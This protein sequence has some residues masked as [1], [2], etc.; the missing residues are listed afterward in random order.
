MS[1]NVQQHGCGRDGLD[2]K[3][4]AGVEG[5]LEAIDAGGLADEHGTHVAL[6]TA[7]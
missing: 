6:S 2:A 4:S 5:A 7:T 3:G 1:A